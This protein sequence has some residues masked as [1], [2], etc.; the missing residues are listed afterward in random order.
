MGMDTTTT[1]ILSRIDNQ[2]VENQTT[3]LSL[4][5]L[6]EINSSSNSGDHYR[7]KSVKSLTET[8]HEVDLVL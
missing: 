6:E 7:F 4:F 5:H 3:I 1:N 8:L 2:E